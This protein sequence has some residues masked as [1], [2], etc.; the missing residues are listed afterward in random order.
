MKVR[1]DSKFFQKKQFWV[2]TS[3][4]VEIYIIQVG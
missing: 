4:L 1:E 2:I 3:K